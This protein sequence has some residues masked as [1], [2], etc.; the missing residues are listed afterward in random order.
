MAR[1]AS[2]PR[3]HAPQ[4]TVAT[5]RQTPT[6]PTPLLSQVASHA[7]CDAPEHH[8][9]TDPRID[10]DDAARA[11]VPSGRLQDPGQIIGLVWPQAQDAPLATPLERGNDY[12][13]IYSFP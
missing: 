2:T 10:T 7:E 12:R 11:D 8:D 3:A 13:I 5:S 6:D 4:S 9:A 1:L